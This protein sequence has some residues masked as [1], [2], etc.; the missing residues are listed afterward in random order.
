M[1]NIPMINKKSREMIHLKRSCV[2]LSVLLISACSYFDASET[3]EVTSE[4]MEETVETVDEH[5]VGNVIYRKTEGAVE[6]YNLDKSPE[7]AQSAYPAS[8]IKGTETGNGMVMN[9]SV[10][11]YPIDIPMQK[12]LK[13]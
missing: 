3:I 1:L 4:G 13:P 12:T 10:E 2:L 9:P 5:D 7:D 11:I 6:I 8:T